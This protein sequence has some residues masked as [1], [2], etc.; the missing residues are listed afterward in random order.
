[1]K[2]ATLRWLARMGGRA[3]DGTLKTNQ[4]TLTVGVVYGFDG[5]I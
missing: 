4:T 5:T 1:V 3:S 2:A